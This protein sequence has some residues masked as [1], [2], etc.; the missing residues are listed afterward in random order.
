VLRDG[1]VLIEGDRIG[2]DGRL[3]GKYRK[4]S[5]PFMD[6]ARSSEPR[7]DEARAEEH[8]L[9]RDEEPFEGHSTAN[10]FHFRP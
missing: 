7:G 8:D 2:P 9:G 3:L 1:A 5:I 4:A 6:R 10:G